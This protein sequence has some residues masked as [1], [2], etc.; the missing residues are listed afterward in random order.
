MAGG[1]LT[2]VILIR[3]AERENPAPGAPALPGPNLTT[4]GQTRARLLIHVLGRAGVKNI[5]VSAYRR[6]KQTA[7]FLSLEFG[8]PIVEMGDPTPIKTDILTNFVGKTVL[9]VGHSDTVPQLITQ[10]GG[11]P[12]PAI[13][14][15]EF[16]NMFVVTVFS[17]GK[18]GVC[19]LKYGKQ[20]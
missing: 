19:K 18:T 9:V 15:S 14:D 10:L 12:Q 7:K 20:S 4:A 8:I 13:A 6:T 17:G 2:T 11:G 1:T 3:H 16:D 5:Y